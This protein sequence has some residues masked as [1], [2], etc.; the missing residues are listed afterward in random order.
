MSCFDMAMSS[1]AG[2][3]GEIVPESAI[4]D[5]VATNPVAIALLASPGESGSDGSHA[6][7]HAIDEFI[8]K[9][10]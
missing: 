1:R 6:S 3:A 5:E 9:V 7:L 4:P 8:E 2:L 10:F